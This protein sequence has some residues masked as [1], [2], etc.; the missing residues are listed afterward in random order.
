MSNLPRYGL[1][2]SLSRLSDSVSA[3]AVATAETSRTLQL[4]ME[5]AAGRVLH[6]P[7]AAGYD[8]PAL[9]LSVRLRGAPP[10]AGN[11]IPPGYALRGL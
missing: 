7:D 6:H 10:M 5:V 11:L 8:V 3:L 2:R 9:R 1:E 4:W